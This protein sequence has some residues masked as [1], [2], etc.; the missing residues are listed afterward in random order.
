[1]SAA[2][3]LQSRRYTGT[4][5]RPLAEHQA[6]ITLIHH[7]LYNREVPQKYRQ[8]ILE[9]ACADPAATTAV[10]SRPFGQTT[11]NKLVK[12]VAEQQWDS[13][14]GMVASLRW[15]LVI[16]SL[17]W[18]PLST[19]TTM[20]KGMVAKSRLPSG[21]LLIVK[22]NDESRRKLL[23]QE[24]LELGNKWHLFVPPVR[25][26]IDCQDEEASGVLSQINRIVETGGVAILNVP[27]DVSVDTGQPGFGHHSF[28]HRCQS[29]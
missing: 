25:R 18:S 28:T 19:L 20:C 8:E 1:M 13:L 4:T 9:L 6:V 3:A 5:W 7:L 22:G 15:A 23:A 24:I 2:T 21:V 14:V 10:L 12:R 26:I 17:V 27:D 11:A 16:R 29:G